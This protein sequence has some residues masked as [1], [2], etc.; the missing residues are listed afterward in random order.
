ME[1]PTF[2]G[3]AASCAQVAAPA[4]DAIRQYTGE[5][6]SETVEF[7]EAGAAPTR[8]GFTEKVCLANYSDSSVSTQPES[9]NPP[10]RRT[11]HLQ[12]ALRLGDDAISAAGRHIDKACENF[13]ECDFN[14]EIADESFDG[15]AFTSSNTA[16]TMFRVRNAII[17]VSVDGA[18]ASSQPGEASQ[19]PEISAL[20]PGARVVAEAMAGDT[21]AFLVS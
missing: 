7:E 6:Y 21:A 11:F 12:I 20:A 13:D 15:S 16:I 8:P 5:L 3:I 18:D 9:G 1:V 14:S 10:L 2:S 19:D 17:S 4:M